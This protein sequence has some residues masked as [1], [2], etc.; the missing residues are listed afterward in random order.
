[1]NQPEAAVEIMVLVFLQ[2][3]ALVDPAEVVEKDQFQL[4]QPAVQEIL[5]LRALLKETTQALVAVLATVV[6]EVVQAQSVKRVVQAHLLVVTDQE[7]AV[8]AQ[9]HGQE[10]LH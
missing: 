3:E 8:Q 6:A 2:A 10:I 5:L 1:M 7:M 4:M 9:I